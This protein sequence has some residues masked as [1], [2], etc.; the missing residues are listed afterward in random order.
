MKP[1]AIGICTD[2]LAPSR[3]PRIGRNCASA[4]APV[5]TLTSPPSTAATSPL[6][7]SCC[8][9]IAVSSHPLRSRLGPTLVEPGQRLCPRHSHVKNGQILRTS[10]SLWHRTPGLSCCRKPERS[11]ATVLFVK[12][13][14]YVMRSVP[15]ALARVSGA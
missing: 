1:L 15:P 3:T 4:A 5:V 12:G 6:H 2:L 10:L 13:T 8:R 9:R 14:L 7:H 11:G